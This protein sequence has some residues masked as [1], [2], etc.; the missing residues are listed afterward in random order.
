MHCCLYL[1]GHAWMLCHQ[2]SH[3][4]PWIAM[5]PSLSPMKCHQV[6]FVSFES[7]FNSYTANFLARWK[8]TEICLPQ[9]YKPWQCCICIP[10]DVPSQ[11]DGRMKC[12]AEQRRHVAF[13]HKSTP[14]LA[15]FIKRWHLLLWAFHFFTFLLNLLH[16][17]KQSSNLSPFRCSVSSCGGELP[18][19]CEVSQRLQEIQ[20]FR[21][22]GSVVWVWGHAV[23]R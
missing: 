18:S 1:T 22:S 3:L 6:S 8:Q 14:R 17:A 19:L 10:V 5:L 9:P 12:D 15:K 20:H 23:L 7:P 4:L 21:K 16:T 11:F 13:P 2:T